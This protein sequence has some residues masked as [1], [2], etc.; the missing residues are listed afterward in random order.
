MAAVEILVQ[1]TPNGDVVI[2]RIYTEGIPAGRAVRVFIVWEELAAPEQEQ[3]NVNEEALSLFIARIKGRPLL[4]AYTPFIDKILAEDWA[5]PI[6]EVDVD[7]DA[8][9]WNR[10]WDEIEFQMEAEE[11]AEQEKTVRDIHSTL[12]GMP[13]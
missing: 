2:P 6:E 10:A 5:N 4:P 1:V 9:D 12:Q 8:A 13:L 3:P 7:F 11:D